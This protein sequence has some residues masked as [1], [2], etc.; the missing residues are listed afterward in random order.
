MERKPDR[1]IIRNDGERATIVS[2]DGVDRAFTCLGRNFNFVKKTPDMEADE[3]LQKIYK[4]WR[5]ECK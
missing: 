5:N 4:E 2:I 1:R 3:K